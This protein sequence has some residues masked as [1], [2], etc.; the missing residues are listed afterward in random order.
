MSAGS[1]PTWPPRMKVAVPVVMIRRWIRLEEVVDGSQALGLVVPEVFP[2]SVE[3]LLGGRQAPRSLDHEES[4]RRRPEEVELAIGADVVDASVRSGVSEEDESLVE[5]QGQAVSHRSLPRSHASSR[6]SGEGRSQ[7]WSLWMISAAGRPR[8]SGR[9]QRI[10][11]IPSFNTSASI[12]VAC[13]GSLGPK[14]SA[15]V[16]PGARSTENPSE[17]LSRVGMRAPAHSDDGASP[18]RSSDHNQTAATR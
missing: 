14:N 17:T 8:P 16:P 7:G 2:N 1:T 3:D 18:Q 11:K 9:R 12:E 5:P 10:E 13:P 15:S 4:I 6:A